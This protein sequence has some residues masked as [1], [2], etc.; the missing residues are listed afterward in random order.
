MFVKE[1]ISR[2]SSTSLAPFSP[3]AKFQTLTLEFSLNSTSQQRLQN[4]IEVSGLVSWMIYICS[5]YI[6][7]F[8]LCI[9]VLGSKLKFWRHSLALPD[10]LRTCTGAYRL[11]INARLLET[12]QYF[13]IILS[14]FHL[15]KC[16]NLFHEIWR[17][18]YKITNQNIYSHNR[19]L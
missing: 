17:D 18:H 10:P 6:I 3:F 19:Y 7:Q 13:I 8:Q 16:R 2:S 14:H 4:K 9:Q 5:G 15:Q 1:D 12:V 11:V